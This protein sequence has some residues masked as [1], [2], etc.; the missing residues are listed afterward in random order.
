MSAGFSKD[1]FKLSLETCERH[2]FRD[3]WDWVKSLVTEKILLELADSF[4]HN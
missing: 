2:V 3:M 4:L 1:S